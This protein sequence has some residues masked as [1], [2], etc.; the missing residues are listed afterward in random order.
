MVVFLPHPTKA[1][2][3][4]SIATVSIKRFIKTSPKKYFSYE[5]P[6]F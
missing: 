3:V 1:K 5:R 6:W 4:S 2:A